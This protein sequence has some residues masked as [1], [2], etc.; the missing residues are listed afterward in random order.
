MKKSLL[1]EETTRNALKIRNEIRQGSNL[2]EL[3]ALE[4]LSDIQIRFVEIDGIVRVLLEIGEKATHQN[5]REA[6]PFVIVIRHILPDT[7]IVI[8]KE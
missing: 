6:I 2:W 7:L 5:I 1:S 8:S 3:D 4:K